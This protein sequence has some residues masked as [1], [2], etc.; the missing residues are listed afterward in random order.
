MALLYAVTSTGDR[1]RALRN[2]L[3]SAQNDPFG[4]HH[5]TADPEKADVILFVATR[6]V[7]PSLRN[8][9]HHPLYRR[10]RSRC[11]AY[12]EYDHVVPLV[13]GIYPSAHRAWSFGN[14][15]RGGPYISWFNATLP[16]D[17][18]LSGVAEACYLFSFVGAGRH[19]QVRKEILRLKHPQ[20]LVRDTSDW[21]T[22][23]VQTPANRS[24]HRHR[25]VESLRQSRFVLCPRGLGAAS[26]RLFETMRM[27]RAPV[28][29]SDAWLPPDG[30]DWDSFA[31]RVRER[32]VSRLPA[33][34][35]A[36]A[37][38]AVRMGQSAR[39]AWETWFHPDVLFHRFAEACLSIS[40][41][42]TLSEPV[43]R[44]LA[45]AQFVFHPPTVKTCLW[46]MLHGKR[47]R[48]FAT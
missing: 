39:Q 38:D 12:S 25:Y 6:D 8:I 42:R 3:V 48:R 17:V 26:A 14:R 32:D 44:P 19:A 37:G 21:Y 11:F 41:S 31:L 45:A 10:F 16:D 47:E 22:R 24:A 13:P 18:A 23:T 2:L 34:L 7:G 29:L 15:V 20:G 35:E 30:P 40:R 27:A 46:R 33:L 9:R 28:I 43:A 5:L 4:A 36:R 1:G